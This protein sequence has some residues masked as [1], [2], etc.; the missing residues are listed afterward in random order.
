MNKK[1]IAT[2]ILSCL[3]V[4]CLLLSSVLTISF[5]QD[6]RAEENLTYVLKTFNYPVDKNPVLWK[7]PGETYARPLSN[8]Y[9]RGA[10]AADKNNFKYVAYCMDWGVK[11]PSSSGSTYDHPT[12]TISQEKINQLTYVLM[13]GYSGADGANAKSNT[14]TLTNKYNVNRYGRPLTLT[15]DGGIGTMCMQNATQIAVWLIMGKDGRGRDMYESGWVSNNN[16]EN[17]DKDIM[18]MATTL[19]HDALEYGSEINWLSTNVNDAVAGVYNATTDSKLYGPFIAESDFVKNNL[20]VNLQLSNAPKGTKIINEK[21]NEITSID[22]GER[23]YV[24]VPVTASDA[25]IKVGLTRDMG[26]VL[27]LSYEEENENRQRMFFSSL[28]SAAT[29]LSIVHSQSDA[30]LTIHKQV[31][32]AAPNNPVNLSSPEGYTFLVYYFKD[33]NSEPQYLGDFETGADGTI[34]LTGLTPGYYQVIE[35]MNYSQEQAYESI[36]VEGFTDSNGNPLA[37][38]EDYKVKANTSNGIISFQVKSSG[39]DKNY[40]V[41]FLNQRH[42]TTK[43]TIT[44]IDQYTGE[45]ISGAHFRIYKMTP[46]A[47]GSG[48]DYAKDA[49]GNY[50]YYDGYT[51]DDSMGQVIFGRTETNR[52]S[53]YL[54]LEL[55]FTNGEV[56]EKYNTYRVVEKTPITGY[57]SDD[58]DMKFD[59]SNDEVNKVIALYNYTEKYTDAYGNE[60]TGYYI[61]NRPYVNALKITKYETATQNPIA[62]V[63]FALYEEIYGELNYITSITTNA[64]GIATYGYDANGEID[65]ENGNALRYGRKYYIV[66]TFVPDGYSIKDEMIEVPTVESDLQVISMTVENDRLEDGYFELVKTDG[67]GEPLSGT[68]FT[69]YRIKDEFYNEFDEFFLSYKGLNTY[70]NADYKYLTYFLDNNLEIDLTEIEGYLEYVKKYRTGDNGIIKDEISEGE[71]ILLETKATT[72]YN[73]LNAIYR[74]NV[75]KN[76]AYYLIECVND[77]ITGSVLLNKTNSSNGE[78]ISGVEFTLYK[79]S[80]EIGAPDIKIGSYETDKNGK[81]FIENLG[82]GEYYFLETK[83]PD[84]FIAPDDEDTKEATK[85]SIDIQG[86]V[87]SLSYTNDEKPCSVVIYKTEK[88]TDTPIAGAKF[89]LMNGNTK[90]AEAITDADG[91]ATF[92]GLELGEYTLVEIATAPGYDINSFEPLTISVTTYA[93]HKV[94]VNNDKIKAD[95]KILKVDKDSEKPL[96]DVEFSLYKADDTD[97][98]LRTL[99]TN[100]DGIVIFED[101]E[102]GDY[103]VIETKTLNGYKTSETKTL[104]KVEEDKEYFYTIANEMIKRTI[105]LIKVDKDTTIPI[106]NVEFDVYAI[107]DGDYVKYTTVTTDENGEC[108]FTL[109]FGQY[110]LR[111]T[112][113]GKGYRI[114]NE[115]TKIDLTTDDIEDILQI[116]ITNELIKNKITVRKSG[117][118]V[119]NYLAGA[120]YGLYDLATDQLILEGVTDENGIFCFGTVSYGS[121]YLKEIEAPEG[122]SLSSDVHKFTV[123]ENSPEE[124]IIDVVDTSVPQTDF[125]SNMLL[126]TLLMALSACLFVAI[127]VLETK[128][129][130]KAYN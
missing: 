6:T 109:P 121:Y 9:Y 62:G 115:T 92:T 19:Y 42:N 76:E 70:E 3:L 75:Y 20:K 105:K 68:E 7:Y 86:E 14:F 118:E 124:Q 41:Y 44:K 120:K 111:E 82:Y 54:P 22:V 51:Y 61:T 57:K 71:Y 98:A 114:S 33:T 4:L 103:V 89:A 77:P 79:K 108:N 87:E 18:E 26:R 63:Q 94:F 93:T 80:S 117:D 17:L 40:N 46:K 102:F 127:V 96:E 45:Y 13:N 126:V 64:Q 58:F 15:D 23:F 36:V 53:K 130:A 107:I 8:T 72:G 49:N 116:T 97:N 65:T 106:A 37:K 39:L 50:I 2:R 52:G 110:E 122:Y 11:G 84:R 34:K 5:T 31:N 67:S 27:P 73:L 10:S 90:V 55:E 28:S 74:F 66:E 104:V 60:H 29:T 35:A 56:L 25:N 129:R 48:F 91:I 30:T 38:G 59:V 125:N 32:D 113:S 123:D 21:F 100:A 83:T 119:G 69:L 88:G 95:I 16:C 85:F 43:L 99:K 78:Y 128:A 112:K 101:V 81:I 12:T 24:S 1:N 47:S